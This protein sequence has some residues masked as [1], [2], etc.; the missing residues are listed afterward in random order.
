MVFDKRSIQ[1][2]WKKIVNV[3]PFFK[4]F[5]SLFE[6]NDGFQFLSHHSTLGMCLARQKKI[7]VISVE[8]TLKNAI[9][10]LNYSIFQL[11]LPH[12]LVAFPRVFDIQ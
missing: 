3:N 5:S 1:L 2:L 8:E 4:R 6:L 12:K 7:F 10:M 9:K 11:L